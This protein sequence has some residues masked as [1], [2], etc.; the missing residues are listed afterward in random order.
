MIHQTIDL[1]IDYK[2]LGLNNG[3]HKPKLTTY[4]LENSLEIDSNR[5]RPCVLICP[6][7]AYKGTSD[8]EAEAVAMKLNAAG[9]HAMILRYSVAPATFPCSL[10]ELAFSV[11]MVRSKAKAWHIDFNKI[12]VTGFSAGGHLACSLGVFWNAPFLNKLLGIDNTLIRPNG[13]GLSY[14]VITSGEYA[15][16][17]SFSNLLAERASDP[18]MM[19]YISLEQQVRDTAPPLF[20]WHTYDDESVPVENTLLLASAYKAHNLPL[21]MHI[22]PKGPHGLSLA[23]TETAGQNDQFVVPSCQKWIDLFITWVSNL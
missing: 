18:K 1:K 4:L 14:P 15:H 22:F 16:K 7:G 17:E 2:A 20:V 6:G 3:G 13:V 8:R 10:L 5:T 23:N 11:A 9:Y 19:Q 21:E 12:I